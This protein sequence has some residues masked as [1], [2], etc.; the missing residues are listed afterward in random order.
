MV[1]QSFIVRIYHFNDRS[2]DMTGT[3][4]TPESE[5]HLAFHGI[6]E[7]WDI[8]RMLVKK[9]AQEWEHD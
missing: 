1:V 9:E 3:I 7:L 4:Q 2:D 8:L 5:T 6:E